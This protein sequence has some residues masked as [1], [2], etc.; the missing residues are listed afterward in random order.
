MDSSIQGKTNEK[1]LYALPEVFYPDQ[2]IEF[3]DEQIEDLFDKA[4]FENIKHNIDDTFKNWAEDNSEPG[5]HTILE[6]MFVSPIEKTEPIPL[7]TDIFYQFYLFSLFLHEKDLNYIS[8]IPAMEFNSVGVWGGFQIFMDKEEYSF[9]K[10]VTGPS[11]LS[12]IFSKFISP[13]DI[14]LLRDTVSPALEETKT[15]EVQRDRARKYADRSGHEEGRL[16]QGVLN[17]ITSSYPDC[18]FGSQNVTHSAFDKLLCLIIESTL[19]YG[20]IWASYSNLS[21]PLKCRPWTDSVSNNGR[22]VKDYMEDLIE[23][24]WKIALLREL[25]LHFS[26]SWKGFPVD[27]IKN[28]SELFQFE[29][30]HSPTN[31]TINIADEK[32]FKDFKPIGFSNTE[33]K[34]SYDLFRWIVAAMSNTWQ[35]CIPKNGKVS[36]GNGGNSELDRLNRRLAVLKNKDTFN[37]ITIAVGTDSNDE[38]CSFI[39]ICNEIDDDEDYQASFEKGTGLTL[40]LVAEELWKDVP[41]ENIKD[42]LK[43]GLQTNKKIW[44][45]SIRLKEISLFS[46]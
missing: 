41:E 23:Y 44:E 16:Y 7:C 8:H 35:H 38:S 21:L 18:L 39:S 40:L 12:D 30:Q 6:R 14:I 19:H 34:V 15:E 24:G 46:S 13:F 9:F 26:D 10:E 22:K 37:K 17:L 42:S 33:L 27:T 25:G 32:R 3:S 5:I 28:I 20:L 43:F 45:T 29:S 4:A 31:V 1:H 36:S 2:P 11:D